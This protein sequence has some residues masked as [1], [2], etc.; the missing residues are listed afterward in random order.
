[1]TAA[2]TVFGVCVPGGPPVFCYALLRPVLGVGDYPPPTLP[3]GLTA[4]RLTRTPLAGFDAVD[5]LG[6]DCMV[7]GSQQ[8]AILDALAGGRFSIPQECPVEPGREFIGALCEPS[9]I[10][11]YPN[12]VRTSGT[13]ILRLQSLIFEGILDP[14][15]AV[16]TDAVGVGKVPSALLALIEMV[17]VQSG[18]NEAFQDRRRIGTIDRFWRDE[19][20]GPLCGPL[21][22]IVPQKPDFRNRS[23]MLKC[24]IRRYASDLDRPFT[25][26]ITIQNFDE[27]L[28]DHVV[29]ML[30]GQAEVS[31]EATTHITD[32]ILEAFNPDGSIAQRAVAKFNQGF[33]FGIV[34]RGR[35]DLLPAVFDG[36]PES[37]DLEARARLST[38]AFK[39]PAAGPRSG[40]FDALR[41]NGER[42]DAIVGPKRWSG[43]CV[44][45][46]RGA[47]TQIDAIR[48]IKGK[49]EKPGLRHAYLV[50]PFLGSDA[51]QRVIARQGN[52]NI[53]LTIL[54]SPGRVNPDAETPDSEAVDDHLSKLVTIANAWSERLCG[55]IAIIHV[56]RGEVARQAF[57]DRYLCLLDQNGIPTVYLLS[58]SLSKAAGEWPFAISELNR[59]K[60]WQVYHYIQDL[61]RG[62]DGL[63]EL[64]SKEI[65]RSK[66][67]SQAIPNAGQ[68]DAAPVENAAQPTWAPWAIAFLER[69]RNAAYRNSNNRADMDAIVDGCLA[70]WPS[71]VEPAPLAENIFRQIGFR[72]HYISRVAMR[73]ATGNAQQRRVAERLE[74]MHLSRFTGE[75]VQDAHEN[76]YSWQYVEG[77]D[78]LV[79]S[80]GKAVCRRNA[81]TNFVRD[82]FNPVMHSLVQEIEFQRGATNAT[83]NAIQIATCLASL[84]L[85]IAIASEAPLRFR[86]GMACDYVHWTARV[87]RSEAVQIRLTAGE[88]VP[89]FWKDD[90]AFLAR[91][92]L[93]SNHP[94]GKP[95]LDSINRFK[96]DPFVPT[97]FKALLG[98]TA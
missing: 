44:W 12:W 40:A 95:L 79:V 57:H 64:E 11:E 31:I 93:R 8:Q 66:Q 65:W 9:L 5:F 94:L 91:Q 3:A 49:L 25:L 73:F 16:L 39:G 48:W 60:S 58:N 82:R 18:L 26:H 62:T 81:P 29:S 47:S 67:P 68:D 35:S 84:M 87:M 2:L 96:A 6:W 10:F 14:I 38:V 20:S 37:P 53:N 19:A 78:D 7:E 28:K 90:V 24:Y 59:I 55:T 22:D 92:I 61:I 76:G 46:E 77:R 23:P 42:I 80:L 69:L 34:A 15:A 52:E 45:L 13:G 98:K 36:A 50:D 75:L 83:F 86:Q 51:L 17:A 71:G 97:E 43:E 30:A 89:D 32:V 27:I 72:D 70:D 56:K 74:D 85:E 54:V 33:E 4:T 41:R 1:M 21:L 63:R 88:G